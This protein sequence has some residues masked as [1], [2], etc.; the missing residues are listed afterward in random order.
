MTFTGQSADGTNQ[1]YIASTIL[2]CVC[3]AVIYV[4]LV[5]CCCRNPLKSLYDIS[6][7]WYGVIG[8]IAS[9]GS[10]VLVSWIAHVTGETYLTVGMVQGG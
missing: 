6:Y 4:Y 8:L 3:H 5:Y 9:L 7:C 1:S 10:G 2:F